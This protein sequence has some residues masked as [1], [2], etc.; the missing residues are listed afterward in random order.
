M[1]T[2]ILN[3]NIFTMEIKGTTKITGVIGYPVKHSLSPIFQNAAFQYLGLD[4][5]YIPL[6][7]APEDIGKAV[8]GIRVMNFAGVNL[9][10]PHKKNVLPYLDDIDSEAKILGAV[11]TIV[12]KE[13]RLKGYNTDGTGFICSIKEKGIS[14]KG[15]NIF[16]LGAGG[17][18]YA[19]AGALV[20]ENVSKIFI[21]NRTEQ[22]AILLKN[23]ILEN[24]Q[25]ENIFVIPF[26]ERNTKKHWEDI[27][28]LVNTTSVG[29]SEKDVPL[30]NQKFINSLELV[31]DLI[32]NRKT[33]LIKYA[34][35]SG[36]PFLDGLSMLVHQGAVSFELWTGMKAPLEIMKKAVGLDR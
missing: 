32:Y 2:L 1:S 17:S 29:M 20:K 21:C 33:E 18:T 7:V 6:E 30:V 27:H 4:Y 34:E 12:N 8:D 36:I 9:T 19:I 11:N 13:G 24:F 15:K 22:N 14:L 5:V 31:Y 35:R 28:I 16:L 3:V 23:H 25:F 10:I 26:N